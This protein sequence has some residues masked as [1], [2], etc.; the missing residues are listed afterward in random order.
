LPK[1][2]AK[3][4]LSSDEAFTT[5]SRLFS[6]DS[7]PVLLAGF[8]VA[9]QAKGVT[10]DE[11]YGAAKALRAF[12]VPCPAPKDTLDTCGTGGDGLH[13]FN[14]STA[15]AFVVA[16]CGVPVAKHGNRAVTSASGSADVLEALGVNLALSPAQVATCIEHTSFGF[17]NAPSHHHAMKRVAPVR[18][19][20]KLFTIFN[21]LGPLVNPA[22]AA[23]QLLGVYDAR[24]LTPMAQVLQR[25]GVKRAWLV[26]GHDGLDEIT[27]TTTTQ[28]MDV[29]PTSITPMTIDPQDYGIS[30]VRIEDLRGGDAMQNADALR[31]IFAGAKNAYRDCVSLN[32][33]ACLVITGKA[34]TLDE[35]LAL[36]YRTLDDGHA[37]DVLHNVIAFTNKEDV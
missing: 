16:A 34:A 9:L 13:T 21:L 15:T 37:N 5:F 10:P 32:A 19:E 36:A 33:A 7:S 4:D 23:Y 1:L 26:H 2:L 31:A 3:H 17:L 8:L 35:G 6:E 12:A 30:L 25:F 24:M 27:T 20:L 18:R 28:V 11:I 29:T 22:G 14:I